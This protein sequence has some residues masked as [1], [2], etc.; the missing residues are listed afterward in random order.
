MGTIPG[1]VVLMLHAL[2]DLLLELQRVH[3]TRFVLFLLEAL[4][5]PW[6]VRRVY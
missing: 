3:G 2:M 4:E 6:L 5:K 1:Y